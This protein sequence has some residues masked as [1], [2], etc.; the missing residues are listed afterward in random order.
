MGYV[1]AFCAGSIVALLALP[2]LIP[3]FYMLMVLAGFMDLMG[4]PQEPE[5]YTRLKGWLYGRH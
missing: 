2:V 1:L 5:W 3:L 4:A